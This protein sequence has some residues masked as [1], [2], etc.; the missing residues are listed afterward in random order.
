MNALDSKIRSG[1]LQAMFPVTP[2]VVPGN[3][4]AGIVDAVGEGVQQFA[5]GDGV[6]GWSE[7]GSYAEFALAAATMVTIR[8]ADLPME[9]AAALPTAVETSERVLDLLGVKAGETVVLHGAAGA[10]GTIAVQLAITRGARVIATAGPAN[11]DYLTA[12]GAT[13]TVYGDGLVERIRTLSPDGVDAVFDIAGKGAL[14][15]SIVLRGGTDR[16]VTIADFRARQLGITFSAGSSSRPMQ[17]LAEVAREAADGA[18]VTTVTTYPLDQAAAAQDASDTGHA[19][20][21]LVLTVN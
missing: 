2:P 13:A 18:L 3:E 8:P 7:T 21:K 20:G 14:E 5:V 19:R 16:I 4:I 9:R 15:D 10:V 6:F 17:R 11:Q 1:A 12:L